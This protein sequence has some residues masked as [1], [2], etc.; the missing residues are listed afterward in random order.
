MLP[1]DSPKNIRKP[2]LFMMFLGGSKGRIGRKRV[3]V[4]LWYYWIEQTAPSETC[5]ILMFL[6]P[7]TCSKRF[8]YASR[9]T[10]T[11]PD[12]IPPSIYLNWKIKISNSYDTNTIQR[13]Q[14]YQP[15]SDSFFFQLRKKPVRFLR[16]YYKNL[17]HN[18]GDKYCISE[19]FS[20]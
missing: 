5:S 4:V 7:F 10:F 3:K 6:F 17:I 18:N 14:K 20:W 16:L 9:S 15:F 19:Y 8:V 1:F 13:T 2:L 11:N 12:S